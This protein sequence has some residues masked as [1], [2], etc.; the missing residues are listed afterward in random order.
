MPAKHLMLLSDNYPNSDGEF[1]LD[2]EI[3]LIA[4]KFETITVL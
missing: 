1:F 2:D 4:S 3:Q